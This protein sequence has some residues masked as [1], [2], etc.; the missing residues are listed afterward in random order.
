MHLTVRMAWHDSEWNGAVCRDPKANT[1]CVGTHSLLSGRIEKKRDLEFEIRKRGKPVCGFQPEDVPPCYWSINAFGDKKINVVHH[2]AFSWLNIAGIPDVLQPNSVFTWPFKLSFIHEE[3]NKKKHGNYPPDLEDRIR[4]FASKFKPRESIVFF[5]ANYDNP[6]SADDMRYLLLGCSVIASSPKTTR[7]QLPAE[8]LRKIRGESLKVKN[9]PT[10]NWAMQVTHDP[11]HKI[12][13]PYRQYLAHVAAHPEEEELLTEMRVI[14]EEDSLI[15][16]FKYVAMDIDDDKCLYLL[17]ELRKAIKKVQD[18]K[19]RVVDSDFTEEEGRVTALIERAWR[20]R[21]IYPSLGRILSCFLPEENCNQLAEALVVQTDPKNDLQTIL[22]GVVEDENIPPAL[23]RHEDAL[24]DLADSHAFR[25]NLAAWVKLSLFNLTPY[26]IE[27]ITND[28]ALMKGLPSNP[29]LLF[30]EYGSDEEIYLDEP[31]LKD[32]PIDLYK[33]DIGMIPDRRFVKRHRGLQNLAE[34]SPQRIRAVISDYLS[35]IGESAGH[36]YD[37]AENVLN[38]AEESPLIYRSDVRLDRSAITSLQDDYKSHFVEKLTTIREADAL[39]FYLRDI[40]NA[41]IQIKKVV[42]E[43]TGKRTDHKKPRVSFTAHIEQSLKKLRSKIRNFDEAQFREERSRLYR[44]VLKKSFFLLTG[45]PG[46]GKTFEIGKIIE[47]L[48]KAGEDVT[49]L[50]PTGKAALRLSQEIAERTKGLKADTI[51]RFI[52]SRGFGWAYDDWDSLDRLP[53]TEKVTVENL[54]LDESSMIDLEKLKVLLSCIRFTKDLPRRL[55]MVGDENQLPPIGF[56]KPFHDIITYIQSHEKLEHAHYV[57]LRS[58]CRQENDPKILQLAEVFSDKK[59]YYEESLELFDKSG[60]VSRGLTIKRWR[61]REE[62]DKMLME[63]IEALLPTGKNQSGDPLTP[64]Q[65]FNK[66]LGLYD[67]GYVNNKGFVFAERLR[68]DALQCLAPYR[69]GSGG[70]LGVNNAIQMKFRREDDP[71]ESSAYYHSDK[72]I[73]ISNWYWGRGKDRRLV[74]SNGSLGIVTGEG[75]RRKYYFPDAGKPFSRL[76]NE[77]NLELAYSI[78]VHKAQGSDFEHVLLVIPERLT[79]LTKELIYT[80]LTR[81][82]QRLTIFLQDAK[83]NLF[84]VARHRSSLLNR[85]TSIF[86]PPADNKR[87]Y[88]PQKGVLVQSRVEYIIYKALEKS[89]LKF[90]YEEKLPLS[91]RTYP[92][93]PDFTIYFNDGSRLFWEHLGK[94]DC[95]KYSRDWQRRLLDFKEHGLFNSLVTTDDLEGIN[96]EKIEKLI[97]D[98]RNRKLAT[99]KGNAFSSHHYAL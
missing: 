43:L 22:K 42:E 38:A 75:Y 50:A 73:R 24:L 96:S 57:N 1:Y 67:T 5:Y 64:K 77:E 68:L 33:V 72:V 12:L 82:R 29:Y 39:Y 20:K 3:Q 63:T 60:V 30:E 88:E 32:E 40:R 53:N 10:I 61:T 13:L 25:N 27:K 7:F 98:I 59:R 84:E 26:Q 16:G 85:N 19:R 17:Y 9:F 18:H 56:G 93:H 48:I 92:I 47:T 70:T 21:G 23:E 97:E 36:C 71:D 14:I 91:K 28:S 15:R 62:L 86:T 54:V 87:G 37:T 4:Q 44:H 46:S 31:D 8:Q 58:N 89:G 80:A 65:A 81:S 34:D 49:V 11:A 94:L 55:I 99:T 45:R 35:R 51:D 95:R 78:T 52:Y 79:L 69:A 74:L 90:K 2:H 83:I 76:D 41:E 6:V 66:L